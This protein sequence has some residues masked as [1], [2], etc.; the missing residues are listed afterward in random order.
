[1][2]DP[3]AKVKNDGVEEKNKAPDYSLGN[4]RLKIINQELNTL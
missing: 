2:P 1:M 4:L 3:A